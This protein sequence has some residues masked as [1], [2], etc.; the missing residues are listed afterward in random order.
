MPCYKGIGAVRTRAGKISFRPDALG[1]RLVLPC[2]KCIGCKLEH[3]R[4]WALRCVHESKLHDENTWFTLT[5]DEDNLPY[6]ASLVPEHLQLFLKKL[7]KEYDD[8]QIR[9]YAAGEYGEKCQLHGVQG[10]KMCGL[11]GRPHYHVCVFGHDFSDKQFERTTETGFDVF[12]SQQLDGVWG[13]GRTEVGEFNFETAAYTARYC[14]KKIT[15]D[16]AMEHYVRVLCDGTMVEL[17][18][19]FSRM[20][21]GGRQKQGGIGAKH[22]ETYASEIYPMD[23]CVINGV[24]SKPPRYYDKLLEARDPETWETIKRDR[25]NNAESRAEDQTLLR[26][27]AREK[28]KRAQV[29]QLKKTI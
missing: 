14:T 8:K 1:E 7:R 4:Q 6:G 25:K 10:C 2:G 26:R 29:A 27:T 3:S 23:E 12:S 9:F 28:V 5:Y 11:L 18:P 16:M 19:E 17:E 21:L 13:K 15:G 20:S 24:T 22:F